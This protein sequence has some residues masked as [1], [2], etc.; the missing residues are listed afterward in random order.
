[1]GVIKI[2][3]TSENGYTGT[4]KKGNFFGMEHWDFTVCNQSGKMVFHATLSSPYSEEELKNEVD[5]FPETLEMLMS[6]E[7]KKRD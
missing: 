7:R 4:M 3:Y 6:L 2:R 1:M 5:E